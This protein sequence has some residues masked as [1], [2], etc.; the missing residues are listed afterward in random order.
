MIYHLSYQMIRS[1][2]NNHDDENL[3]FKLALVGF[4]WAPFHSIRVNHPFE[5]LPGCVNDD[6]SYDFDDGQLYDDD[7]CLTKEQ[8]GVSS[9]ASQQAAIL[10]LFTEY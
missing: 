2:D 8:Y 4:R 6:H 10:S 5:V 3:S 1:N 9:F 7:S